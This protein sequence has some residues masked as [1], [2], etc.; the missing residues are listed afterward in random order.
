MLG[1]YPVKHLAAED[2]SPNKKRTLHDHSLVV[3]ERNKPKEAPKKPPSAP[4]LWWQGGE[5][6]GQSLSGETSMKE[7]T[8]QISDNRARKGNVAI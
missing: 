5:P 4:S 3:K 6:L 1:R 7:A 2:N 8:R